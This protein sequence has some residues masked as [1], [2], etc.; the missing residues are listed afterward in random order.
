MVVRSTGWSG[1]HGGQV[2]M[3]VRSTWWSGQ[4]GGHSGQVNIV[5]RS[6]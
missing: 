1:H 6:M 2:S 4:H 5:V 3:V